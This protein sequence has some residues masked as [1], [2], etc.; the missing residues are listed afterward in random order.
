MPRLFYYLRLSNHDQSSHA[1]GASG[2]IAREEPFH[3]TE[4]SRKRLADFIVAL[5]RDPSR[6]IGGNLGLNKPGMDGDKP[7]F[8]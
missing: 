8:M 3:G 2:Q 1:L 7:A 5:I 6:D 4:G